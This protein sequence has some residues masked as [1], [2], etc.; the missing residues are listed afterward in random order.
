M[1][2]SREGQR[3]KAASGAGPANDTK[4]PS[5]GSVTFA[6]F[7]NRSQFPRLDCAC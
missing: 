2:K 3:S 1:Q 6:P 5:A 7:G 4:V